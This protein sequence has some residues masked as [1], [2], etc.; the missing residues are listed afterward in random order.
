MDV[1]G[2]RD[3]RTLERI[4]ALLA[5]LAGLAE[6]AAGRSFP[7]RFMVLAILRPAEAIARDHVAGATGLS[8]PASEDFP[9]GRNGAADAM[10][11]AARLRMLAAAIEAV[12]RLFSLFGGARPAGRFR[13]VAPSPGRVTSDGPDAKLHDTS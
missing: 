10:L 3:I 11:L 1:H 8:L 12:L 4:V 5:A 13:P 2:I 6:M 9:A 7:V